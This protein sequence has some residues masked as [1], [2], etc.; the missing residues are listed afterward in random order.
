MEVQ[1][2]G[3]EVRAAA[4]GQVSRTRDGMADV[5]VRITGSD[6]IAE[7][8]CGNGVIIDHGQGWSTQYCHL[9]KGSIR[10]RPGE[11]V[12]AKQPI[13]LVGL[14][15]NTEFP[16][17]HLTVRHNSVV[18]DPFAYGASRGGCNDGHSIWTPDLSPELRY[19]SGEIINAGFSDE[20]VTLQAIETGEVRH[21][22]L[23][24]HSKAIVAYVRAI[25]L[26]AG[27]ELTI[28]LRLPDGKLLSEYRSPKLEKD[29]AQYFAFAGK[30][31]TGPAWTP[32]N[33]TATCS[34]L[35]MGAEVE[36]RTFQVQI[37]E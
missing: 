14:S 37:D 10:V 27:D 30:K 29:Q 24:S 3:V 26:E 17:L 13:G 35:R 15:G 2:E 36:R 11:T 21:H 34:L 20:A 19:Q 32:G 5:S 4:P 7:R 9:A 1:R 16:H 28:E 25:G 6:T 12:G 33:Y 31:L 23:S 22:A 8:D 18:V